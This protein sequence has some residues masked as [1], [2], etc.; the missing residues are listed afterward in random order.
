M[1]CPLVIIQW[2][3]NRNHCFQNKGIRAF[4]TRRDCIYTVT[5]GVLTW[6]NVWSYMKTLQPVSKRY[7]SGLVRLSCH[8]N[9][10]PNHFSITWDQLPSVL[11]VNVTYRTTRC[12]LPITVVKASELVLIR[13][14]FHSH[15]L[16]DCGSSR[17]PCGIPTAFQEQVYWTTESY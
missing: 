14:V 16:H 5:S 12:Q 13:L 3:D 11:N 15:G 7:W 8:L 4:Q 2:N 17:R 10:H 1:N 9:S 6:V